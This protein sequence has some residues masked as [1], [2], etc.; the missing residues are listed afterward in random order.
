MK[1]SFLVSVR[2][3]SGYIGIGGVPQKLINPRRACAARVTVVVV[4]V[5]LSVCPLSHISPLGLLFV[6]K[7]LLRTQQATKVKI[8]VVISSKLLRCR[9]R[10]L[11]PMTAI[12]TGH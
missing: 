11:P 8:F 12:Q 6:V 10:A 1:R 9:D 2:L 4:S 5:C 7:T 3:W